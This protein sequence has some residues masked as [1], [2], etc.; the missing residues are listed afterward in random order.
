MILSRLD[1]SLGQD[2]GVTVTLVVG[3]RP[4]HEVDRLSRLQ[5]GHMGRCRSTVPGPPDRDLS[6]STRNDSPLERSV[7]SMT[8]VTSQ[9]S[10]LPAAGRLGRFDTDR[11]WE[12]WRMV[13]GRSP[14]TTLDVGEE[15][16]NDHQG[17]RLR[18]G[19]GVLWMDYFVYRFVCHHLVDHSVVSGVSCLRGP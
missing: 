15:G 7:V 12:T 2:D 19:T 1:P 16:G 14:T 10:W 5:V 17:T 3:L 13:L 18:V 6:V 8:V 11:R 9:R 4:C